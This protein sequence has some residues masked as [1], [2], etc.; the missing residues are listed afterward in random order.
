MKLYKF[1]VCLALVA[2]VCG[3]VASAFW[4]GDDQAAKPRQKSFAIVDEDLPIDDAHACAMLI[5]KDA[6]QEIVDETVAGW[7]KAGLAA[8]QEA[9][10][11][12]FAERVA[13]G[14]IR[15]ELA[16]ALRQTCSGEEIRRLHREASAKKPDL[17]TS[18][19]LYECATTRWSSARK[20]LL[21]LWQTTA[22]ASSR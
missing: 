1:G 9:D 10:A 19:K 15:W 7:R 18:E 21:T 14:T 22:A 12:A 13:P 5:L 2:I 3:T 16:E 6:D 4:P 11:Q 8:K 17:K 20:R